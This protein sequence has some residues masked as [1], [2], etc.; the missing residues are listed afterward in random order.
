MI[1]SVGILQNR[2]NCLRWH[3]PID[4]HSSEIFFSKFHHSVEPFPECEASVWQRLFAELGPSYHKIGAVC[5]ITHVSEAELG[6]LVFSII[7]IIS[8][9]PHL[10]AFPAKNFK[11]SSVSP[12]P[13]EALNFMLRV[14]A[15]CIQGTFSGT[16]KG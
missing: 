6:T 7:T 3:S 16:R 13:Q 4:P 14:L 11:F 10:K 5:V 12:R 15:T 2:F 8:E 1:R 9:S